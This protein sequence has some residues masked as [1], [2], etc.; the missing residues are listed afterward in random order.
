MSLSEIAFAITYYF[1][2][3]KRDVIYAL[4]NKGVL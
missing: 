3:L 1:D 2:E 4:Q